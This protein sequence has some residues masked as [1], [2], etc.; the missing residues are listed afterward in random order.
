[1]CYLCVYVCYVCVLYVCVPIS[2]GTA[3]ERHWVAAASLQRCDDLCG[4]DG[5]GS[6]GGLAL[7]ATTSSG[8]LACS[9]AVPA[10]CKSPAAALAHTSLLPPPALCPL[11]VAA[12]LKPHHRLPLPFPKHHHQRTQETYLVGTARLTPSNLQSLVNF[13]SS[14][15]VCALLRCGPFINTQV[16]DFGLA[17]LLS[18]TES[19][20]VTRT[21]G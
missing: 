9:V 15:C 1:M 10:H 12:L 5:H 3:Q 2:A 17:R 4:L 8:W 18:A 16:A 11:L 13:T 20:V 6:A 19:I 7:A 14:V 21:Y